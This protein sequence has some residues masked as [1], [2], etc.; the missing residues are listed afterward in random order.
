[1]CVIRNI[2]LWGS[3]CPDL[4]KFCVVYCYEGH[5]WDLWERQTL[6]Y[7]VR[8][9][10]GGPWEPI[11]PAIRRD[12]GNYSSLSWER[13][14]GLITHT[15]NRDSPQSHTHSPRLCFQ[16]LFV[17]GFAAYE[18]KLWVSFFG[19][20]YRVYLSN[21]IRA[22]H[23]SDAFHRR[24]HESNINAVKNLT[25]VSSSCFHETQNHQNLFQRSDHLYRLSP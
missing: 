13:A 11:I 17:S 12:I 18:V 8:R 9:V 7:E 3:V 15:Q 2:R 14:P 23:A 20:N 21:R 25:Y 24:I 5:E 4:M 19:C 16:S 6:L 10:S 1:M 22:S